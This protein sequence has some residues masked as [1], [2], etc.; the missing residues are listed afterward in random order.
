[1]EGE[2]A[3]QIDDDIKSSLPGL[4]IISIVMTPLH[5]LLLLCLACAVPSA[6]ATHSSVPERS[7]PPYSASPSSPSRTPAAITTKTYR[8][9]STDTPRST[10]PSPSN[11]TS[12]GTTHNRQNK[13]RSSASSRSG[14]D[15]FTSLQLRTT[16]WTGGTRFQLR[17]RRRCSSS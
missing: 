15:Q 16:Q 9:I 8:R 10:A 11:S 4:Y 5:L 3:Y 2:I 13:H 6:N 1:M 7:E 12:S 17:A 14:K